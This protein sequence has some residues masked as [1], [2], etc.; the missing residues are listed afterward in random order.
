MIILS[1]SASFLPSFPLLPIRPPFSPPSSLPSL[2]WLRQHTHEH[3]PHSAPLLMRYRPSCRRPPFPSP[4]SS[5]PS[6]LQPPPLHRAR[7]SSSAPPPPLIVLPLLFHLLMCCAALMDG[8]FRTLGDA[9]SPVQARR[10]YE[11]CLRYLLTMGCQSQLNATWQP[12]QDHSLASH[13]LV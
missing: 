4:P 9:L 6:S 12:T 11:N 1:E 7:S 2:P 13:K 8:I 10:A 5:P 3:R